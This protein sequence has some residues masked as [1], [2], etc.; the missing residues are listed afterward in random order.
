MQQGDWI[1]PLDR[2]MKLYPLTFKGETNGTTSLT[3]REGVKRRALSLGADLV[4]VHRLVVFTLEDD[5]SKWRDSLLSYEKKQTIS[6]AEFEAA[7][8]H[9]FI[10]E[11]V[12]T[13]RRAEFFSLKMGDLSVVDFERKFTS[14]AAF[15]Q[16]VVLRGEDNG[17]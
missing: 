11:A 7:F 15:S 3:W 1:K 12:K 14:L 5:A 10:S 16:D 13:M 4:Q 6:W 9:R 2:F 17:V 8:D